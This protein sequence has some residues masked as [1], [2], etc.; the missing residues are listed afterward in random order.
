[1]MTEKNILRGLAGGLVIA[2]LLIWMM[3]NDGLTEP[4]GLPRETD[5]DL[6]GDFER[7]YDYGERVNAWRERYGID[8]RGERWGV[9]SVGERYVRYGVNAQ[10][11]RYEIRGPDYR[12]EHEGRLARFVKLDIDADMNY[13]GTIDNY[14]PADQGLY[15]TTPP[16]LILGIEE[17]SKLVIRF[18][19][20]RIGFQ[21]W[22][23]SRVKVDPRARA[24]SD[25]R[26]ETEK[27]EEIQGGVGFQGHA[28]V[29]MEVVGINRSVQS[30]LFKDFE[31]EK[32]G[33]GRIRVW[34]D[35][36]K[37]DLLLDSGVASKRVY[38]WSAE[39]RFF[40]ENLPGGVPRTVY[41]EGVSKSGQYIGDIRLLVTVSWRDRSEKRLG[42]SGDSGGETVAAVNRRADE[43]IEIGNRSYR[44]AYDH[45][46]FTVK[47]EPQR[48]EFINNNVERIW[49]NPDGT[50]EGERVE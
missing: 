39:N 22:E 47:E 37:K 10:G 28:V 9:D 33:T 21:E 49:L 31:Q 26:T 15:E 25:G 2:L 27:W 20:N 32:K 6:P 40:P 30:G 43:P 13:D 34:R 17:M 45:I 35:E 1:M 36:K 41:V 29:T 5:L 16:G 46:L 3:G 50:P 48:K 44:A 7:Y 42:K 11:E 4:V 18:R 38:E 24:N 12:R 19:M 14:D 23:D 8:A